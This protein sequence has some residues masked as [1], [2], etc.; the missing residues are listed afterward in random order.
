MRLC[1]PLGR[2]HGTPGAKQYAASDD[3]GSKATFP[4]IFQR[5]IAIGSAL[6]AAL[7]WWLS[8]LRDPQ[9]VCLVSLVFWLIMVPVVTIGNALTFSHLRDPAKQFGKIRLWGTVGWVA[10][11]WM[12]GAWWW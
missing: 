3:N 12:M 4:T 2:H 7:L 11:G 9:M 1:C 6:G 5:C 10:A 8:E